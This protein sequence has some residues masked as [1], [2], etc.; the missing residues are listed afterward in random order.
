MAAVNGSTGSVSIKISDGEVFFHANQ[1]SGDW[2]IEMHEVTEFDSAEG[3]DDM[4]PGL[5]EFS[6]SASGWYQD[7]TSPDIPLDH[8]DIITDGAAF[9]LTASTG[10]TWTFTGNILSLNLESEKG[11]PT[12]W[13]CTFKATTA[14]VIA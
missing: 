11:V 5:G 13:S 10:R 14:P 7:A 9:I 2:P 4:T 12:P 6:G 8:S 3:Y 1:W